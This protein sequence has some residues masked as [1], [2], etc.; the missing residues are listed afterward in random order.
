MGKAAWK[1][2]PARKW[3]TFH[4]LFD[5]AEGVTVLE[6]PGTGEGFWAGAPSAMYD[7]EAG[8]FYLSYRLRRPGERGFATRVAK[9]P[10]GVHFTDVWSGP[11]E[12][13]DSPSIER[14]ALIRTPEG[15][16]LLYV[17][18]VDGSDNRWRIDALEAE[19]PD[20][21]DPSARRPVLQPDDIDSEGVKDPWVMLLDGVYYLFVGY[22]PR[23]SIAPGA[24]V[25]ELHRTG[26][27]FITRKISHP[28]GLATSRDGLRYR[29]RGEVIR[30]GSGWDS[31]ASRVSC[32]LYLPPVFHVFYDGRQ[33]FRDTYEDRTGL[34]VSL[35]LMNFQR[36]T[37]RNPL[38]SSP[39]G[40]GSLRYLDAVPIGDSI[41]YYYECARP[42]G[43][44]ELR[45]NLVHLKDHTTH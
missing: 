35:D 39:W 21:F 10:D 38:L 3:L 17:S 9:S 11:R 20:G 42:D 14:S 31:I 29:W 36:V 28:S 13:F 44:H 7:G 1:T 4:R 23:D 26:D 2:A 32:V 33:G 5:P 15:R 43:S 45:T 37:E 27:I 16:Y 25:R 18:Y 34:A 24:D 6:P 12:A 41:R 22:G 8:L 19:A 30:P 40:S